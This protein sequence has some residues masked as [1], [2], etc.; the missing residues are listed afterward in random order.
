MDI[1]AIWQDVYNILKES[2]QSAVGF[3]IHIKGAVP[4]SAD[5]NTFTLS[6]P[7]EINKNMLNFRYRD[8][9]ESALEQVTGKKF[10]LSIILD[11]DINYN[12]TKELNK[13]HKMIEEEYNPSNSVNPKFTFE[14]FVVGTSNEYA[15][16]AAMDATKNPAFPNPLFIY[17]NSGLGKTH[18]MH[19]IG[20]RILDFNPLAEVMYVTSEEFTNQFI[21]SIREKKID[22]FRNKFRSVDALLVDDIQ[23]IETKDATQEEFFHT[24]NSLNNSNKLIV[25]TS[26][27]KPTEILTL[28]ARLRTRFNGGLPI[29]IQAP[30]Y[31]T[32]VAILQKK[33]ILHKAEISDEVL[34]Y[35]ADKIKS[36]VRELEGILIKMISIAQIHKKEYNKELADYVIKSFLPNDGIIKITPERIIDKV[37]TFYNVSKSEILGQSRVKNIVIPRQVGMYLCSKLTSLNYVVIGN[38]FGNKDRTTVTHNIEKIENEMKTNYELDMQIKQIINDLNNITL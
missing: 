14:N 28:S 17:G 35:I 37:C 25:L 12:E 29:D 9:I 24:F 34:E 4:V 26:D 36:S 3:N 32:R 19:A 10:N 27:R 22:E 5:E 38:E 31:E 13:I 18:L 16:S 20:N 8:I 21:K 33:A 15:Y 2:P 7:M 6:V 30:N 23:F 1:T 11:S